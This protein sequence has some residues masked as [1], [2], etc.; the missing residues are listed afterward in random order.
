[1]SN[2]A[3]WLRDPAHWQGR[4]RAIED[5]L[6]DALHEQLTQR[7]VD[8]KTSALMRGLRDKDELSAEIGAD[9]AINVENHFVGRLKGFRFRPIPRRMPRASTAR[10]RAMPPRRCCRRSSPCGRGA[11]P[12]PR[13]TPSSSPQRLRILWRDEEIARLEPGEDPLKPQVVLLA[14]EHLQAAD[15]EKV[16]ERLNTWI[17]ELIGERLKPLVELKAAEDVRRGLARGIAFR[18]VESFGVLKRETVADEMR[19]STSRR[20]R[21][22]A[23]T[24]C[25]SAPSTSSCRRC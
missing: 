12:R 23:S 6:S 14:D 7:F 24:A 18:L 10:R 11:S 25:V 19:S 20:A 4:T 17:T 22:C 9:G 2:R 21:S 13:P 15:K 1:M 3:D 16:Q 8:L 5:S